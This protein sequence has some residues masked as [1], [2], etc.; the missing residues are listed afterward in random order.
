VMNLQS[1]ISKHFPEFAASGIEVTVGSSILL[2]GSAKDRAR[3][4]TNLAISM[5][6][7]RLLSKHGG[8][9]RSG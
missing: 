7:N 6:N 1:S 5:M 4:T 9:F 2:Q 8:Q 3:V